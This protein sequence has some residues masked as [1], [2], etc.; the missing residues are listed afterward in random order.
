ML[1]FFGLQAPVNF[2]CLHAMKPHLWPLESVVAIG[3]RDV[4]RATERNG[5]RGGSAS[6]THQI[7]ILFSPRRAAPRTP[8]FNFPGPGPG[9]GNTL[10]RFRV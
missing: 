6:L 4:H 5:I 8:G 3:I 7:H 2:V 9:P 1:H 10:S